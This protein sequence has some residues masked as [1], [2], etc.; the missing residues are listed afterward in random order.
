MSAEAERQIEM[1][2]CPAC[3]EVI[4][5]EARKC[6]HCGEVLDASLISQ[7]LA[8]ASSTPAQKNGMAAALSLFLPGAGQVYKGEVGKGL[9]ILI[10]TAICG[11]TMIL[12]PLAIIFWIRSVRD[13]YSGSARA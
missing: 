2:K 10:K 1:K 3:A 8:V 4:L 12:L 6:K 9:W 13:A 7:R 11:C 5:A